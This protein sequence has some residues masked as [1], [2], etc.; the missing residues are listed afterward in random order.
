MCFAHS[1]LPLSPSMLLLPTA[2]LSLL[3]VLFSVDPVLLWTSWSLRLFFS[4]FFSSDLNL[5]KLLLNEW[6][7]KQ[8]NQER[9]EGVGESGRRVDGYVQC[10]C[11][12]IQNPIKMYHVLTKKCKRMGKWV[13]STRHK[14]CQRHVERNKNLIQTMMQFY[15]HTQINEWIQVKTATEYNVIGS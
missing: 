8:M 9:S 10:T 5:E 4:I 13:W 3:W 14:N 6:T 11:P 7:N 15:T 12:G 2:L 1:H